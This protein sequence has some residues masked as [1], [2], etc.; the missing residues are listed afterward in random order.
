MNVDMMKTEAELEAEANAAT[1][2][3]SGA[4]PQLM[5]DGVEPASLAEA[6]AAACGVMLAAA[7]RHMADVLDN[8]IMNR[9][10]ISR[11][12]VWAQIDAAATVN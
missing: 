1:Q 9:I 10:R 6:L 8:A 12:E 5:D 4:V 2:F 11:A 7:P 3:L